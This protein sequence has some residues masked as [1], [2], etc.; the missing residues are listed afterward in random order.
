M[1]TR[2]C[3]WKPVKVVV[4]FLLDLHL[5]WQGGLT[6]SFHTRHLS[7]VGYTHHSTSP[8][9]FSKQCSSFWVSMHIRGGG[10]RGARRHASARCRR[11]H[12]YPP[13]LSPY[14]QRAGQRGARRLGI[15]YTRD[16]R[17]YPLSGRR[18]PRCQRTRSRT[19]PGARAHHNRRRYQRHC[20]PR[21]HR[22]TWPRARASRTAWRRLARP[23]W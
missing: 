19:N 14:W 17:V 2:Q 12:V 23:T 22:S 10:V 7:Q 9:A 16:G 15:A 11:A 5:P 3:R 8:P 1:C 6:H 4:C 21:A 18:A 20:Q 13:P